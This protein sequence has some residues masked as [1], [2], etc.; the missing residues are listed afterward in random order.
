MQVDYKIVESSVMPLEIDVTSSPGGIYIRRNIEKITTTDEN[1]N[2]ILKYRYQEAYLTKSEYEKYSKDLLVGQINDED[3]TAE[4]EAYKKKLDTGVL[5]KNGKY[6]KPKW[7]DIYY[8]KV[9]EIMT[10]LEAYTKFG[11]DV[12]QISNLTVNIFDVTA[13]EENA[14]AMTAKE[15]IELWLFLTLKQEELFNEYKASLNA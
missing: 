10:M 8:K 11:G 6:Y 15:I 2:E 1:E 9:A 4:Y 5:Y 3:N 13:L 12:A 14:E 7:T